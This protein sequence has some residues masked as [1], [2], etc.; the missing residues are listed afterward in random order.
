MKKQIIRFAKVVV[1][2]VLLGYLVSLI[3]WATLSS[4]FSQI[5]FIFLVGAFCLLL[6]QMAISA[7]KWKTILLTD[8]VAIPYPFLLRTY[9]IGGFIS[10]FLPSSFGG[11]IYRVIAIKDI[12]K[13][14]GKSTS[15]VLFDRLTGLFALV[16]ISLVSYMFLPKSQHNIPI[17]ALYIVGISAFV[18]VTSD[19][20]IHWLQSI[21]FWVVQKGLSVIRSFNVYR[22]SR[23]KLILVLA[24][25]FIFQLNIVFINKV[26]CIALGIDIPLAYL[27]VI[28]PLIYLTETLPI[29]INGLGV[30]ES[31]FVFFF[32][33]IGY[34][35]EEGF[36]VALLLIVMRYLAGLVGGTLLL[37][38]V[39]KSRAQA[40]SDK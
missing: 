24:I 10:L 28:I 21:Q 29:S 18:F 7:Y 27:L 2:V 40:Q 36:A 5:N 39:I 1:S 31:A 34:T 15:S 22:K 38:T 14:L 35:A 30:R 12:N 3:D 20:M 19:R 25:S 6:L 13:S 9:F 17:I 37:T 11:D 4:K 8:S 16:T 33:L 23:H 26:Y 32:V